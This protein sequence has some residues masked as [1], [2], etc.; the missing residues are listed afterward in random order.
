MIETV[1]FFAGI[2]SFFYVLSFFIRK[3]KK[4]INPIEA[5]VGIVYFVSFFIF[6]IGMLS[7]GEQYFTAIYPTDTCY[8]PFSSKHL[9]TLVVYFIIFNIS[10]FIVWLKGL[11]LP[12]L[13]LVLLLVLLVIGLILSVG[14]ISQVSEHNTQSLDKDDGDEERYLF[15]FTPILSF[16]IGISLII[17]VITQKAEE[18]IQRIYSNKI[19]SNIN[20]FLS[21]RQRQPF[22]I[23]LLLLPIFLIIT[24]ILTLFGQD[25]Q[26]IMKVFTDTTTWRFSQQTHPPILTHIGG[27][28][29]CTVAACGD[30]KIVKPLRFGNR[31]GR[32][33][34]VNRQLLIANAFE[35]LLENYLPTFHKFIRTNY[36]KYGYNLSKKINTSTLSN[37]T[38]ILMKPL[39]WLFLSCLYLFCIKP[40]EN[41]MRQYAEWKHKRPTLGLALLGL[42]EYCLSICSLLCF[43]SGSTL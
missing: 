15:L 26:A 2:L 34:I 35:N 3:A 11:K 17:K 38:Y 28:Y 4:K 29:L 41:I 8:T 30:P 31:G 5:I 27:H 9:L 42:D 14:I 21:Y 39:E 22:F 37:L 36:D 43:S 20:N 18:S 16:I 23:V 40:E 1:I 33:I 13:T 19:L 32:K 10:A 12:P 7:H 24:V 6:G 25:S